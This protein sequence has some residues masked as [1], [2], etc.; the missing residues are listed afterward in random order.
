MSRIRVVFFGTAEL[1]AVSLNRL[2][3]EPW[4]AILGVVTQPDQP[5]GR[6]LRLQPTPVKAAALALG[7]PVQQPTRCRD[8]GFLRDLREL[9][10]DVVLVVAYGQ[11]LPAALLAI[12]SQGCVHTSLLP[13][14]RGA[15]PIQWAILAG[16]RE[17]GVTLMKMDVGLDT[18]DLLSSVVT[19][20]EPD[21]NAAT[22]HDRLADLGAALLVE[23]L[24]RYVRGEMTPRPQPA[25]GATYARKI[26]KDDGWVNWAKPAEE[27]GR[28]LRA[29]TP[30][31][32]AFTWHT[33]AAGLRRRLKLWRATPV[34][35]VSGPAGQIV[36]AGDGRLVVACGSGALEVSELQ[37]EGGR[38]L[39]VAEF[40]AGGLL[41][42]GDRLD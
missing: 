22:L 28:R 18:G 39:S 4:A 9:A 31:P 27:I 41:R 30:W 23:S 19:R 29:F 25:E 17:T 1:A 35:E 36:E 33:D 7:L 2:A 12:P 24:P 15:A 6:D 14:H 21:D 11:I 32:G 20:I 26:S 8:E 10:P 42:S 13:R 37:R 3:A 5:R 38:R 40:L 34:A 16:D